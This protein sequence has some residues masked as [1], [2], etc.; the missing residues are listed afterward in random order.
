MTIKGPACD[1]FGKELMVNLAQGVAAGFV[2]PPRPGSCSTAHGRPHRR[3]ER[4][5]NILPQWSSIDAEIQAKKRAEESERSRRQ[6][7]SLMT[8]DELLGSTI[9]YSYY[10]PWGAG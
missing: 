5:L 10:D 8:E 3:H 9:Q 2:W 6:T 1:D 4:V 7:P